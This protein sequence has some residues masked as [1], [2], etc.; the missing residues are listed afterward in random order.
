M[1]G[2]LKPWLFL[3]LCLAQG[4]TGA[5]GIS[6]SSSLKVTVRG[7]L[8]R[9]EAGQNLEKGRDLA[10]AGDCKKALPFLERSTTQAPTL[11]EAWFWLGYCQENTGHY[12]QALRAYQEAYR[13]KP[14]LIEALF[15]IGSVY[16]HTQRYAEAAQTFHEVTVHKPTLA[17]A[18]FYLAAAYL[19]QEKRQE[20]IPALQKALEQGLAD[21]TQALMWLGDTYFELDS[22]PQAAEAYERATRAPSAPGEAFLGLGKARLGMS[23]PEA[24]LPPLQQAV[25]R[26]P[27]SPYAHYYLGLAYR[28]KGQDQEALAAFDKAIELKPDH[29]R[30]HYE[31]GRLRALKGD[32]AGA[33]KHY[34]ALKSLGSRLA[35]NLLPLLLEEKR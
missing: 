27:N 33:Q 6:P 22:F 10:L 30:S 20:A 18:H 29:A 12:E 17:E 3:A 19:M 21:S 5:G 32:K 16:L 25:Q 2:A 15:G 23:D 26:L 35:Q 4:F 7:D 31:A 13:L 9:S 8:P 34:E 14:Q 1:A 24:A 11:A 28:M